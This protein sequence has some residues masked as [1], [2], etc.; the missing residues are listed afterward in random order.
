MKCY[1]IATMSA[2]EGDNFDKA[3][4]YIRDKMPEVVGIRQTTGLNGCVN[5]GICVTKECDKG[6]EE[7]TMALMPARYAEALDEPFEGFTNEL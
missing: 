1:V 6:I 2:F 3:C 4:E 5:L 7:L